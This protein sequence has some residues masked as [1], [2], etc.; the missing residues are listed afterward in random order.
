M[1]FGSQTLLNQAVL[2]KF[3]FSLTEC[4]SHDQLRYTNEIW[5]LM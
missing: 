5:T 4:S 3:V 1:V 2:K